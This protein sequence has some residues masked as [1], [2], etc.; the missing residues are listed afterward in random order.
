VGH[1]KLVPSDHQSDSPGDGLSVI[2]VPSSATVAQGPVG[3]E[4][5]TSPTVLQLTAEATLPARAFSGGPG[6]GSDW[7]SLGQNE[8]R[9]LVHNPGGS[10]DFYVVDM[11]YRN[12]GV[13]GVNQRYYG[14]I[15]LGIYPSVGHA[16]DDQVGAYWRSLTGQ[17]LTVYRRPEDGFADCAQVRIWDYNK[18]VYIPVVT[19]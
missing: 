8:A 5:G 12:S 15:D 7:V 4:Q 1:E 6:Y 11:Q 10:A 18:R 19:K 13:E 2:I 3:E 17:S 9:T 16:V 14:S